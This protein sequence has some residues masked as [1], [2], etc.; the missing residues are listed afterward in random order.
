MDAIVIVRLTE[1]LGSPN[2]DELHITRSSCG[3][4]AKWSHPA[5]ACWMNANKTNDFNSLSVTLAAQRLKTPTKVR[6][7]EHAAPG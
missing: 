1:A 4:V 6:K 3:L 5:S 2:R 7:A